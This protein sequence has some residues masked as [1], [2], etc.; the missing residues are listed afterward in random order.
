M[1]LGFVQ[2]VLS[3]LPLAAAGQSVP[4]SGPTP[5]KPAAAVVI[6]SAA[7]TGLDPAI[8]RA[9]LVHVGKAATAD[10][11]VDLA[12]VFIPTYGQASGMTPVNFGGAGMTSVLYKFKDQR[13]IVVMVHGPEPAH[14]TGPFACRMFMDPTRGKPDPA[15]YAQLVHWCANMVTLGNIDPTAIAAEVRRPSK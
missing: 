15:K 1:P 14:L 10:D 2:I 9:E 7:I 5:V 6:R 13:A 4:L 12:A 11:L 8:A 3:S